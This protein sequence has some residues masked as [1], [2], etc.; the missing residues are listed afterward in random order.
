MAC[1]NKIF[2]C[3]FLTGSL[4]FENKRRFVVNRPTCLKAQKFRQPS[5]DSKQSCTL[6]VAHQNN[7]E[8]NS[9]WKENWYT[10]Y[11]TVMPAETDYGGVVWHGEYFRWLEETRVRALSALGLTYVDIVE[12]LKCEFPVV[13]I[14]WKYLKPA[15]LGDFVCIQ[16]AFRMAGIRLVADSRIYRILSSNIEE[17]ELCGQGKI[18]LVVVDMNSRQV[19]RNLP[20]PL[21]R[22]VTKVDK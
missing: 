21:Q 15:R 11:R 17:K 10:V 22:L 2:S 1:Q 8:N 7:P 6:Q 13:Q 5:Q 3:A 14:D 16:V 12:Q 18:S 20:E 4:L 9:E 19:L